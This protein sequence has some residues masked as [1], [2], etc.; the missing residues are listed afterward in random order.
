MSYFE[1]ISGVGALIGPLLGS[2]FYF[3]LGYVGPFLCLGGFYLFM[4]LVFFIIKIVNDA[5]IKSLN[6][7]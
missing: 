6:K 3:L 4:I 5:K 1:I 7:N 2:L